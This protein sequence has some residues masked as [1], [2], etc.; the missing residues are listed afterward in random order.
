MNSNEIMY[1]S[2]FYKNFNE[3]TPSNFAC[4]IMNFLKDVEQPRILDVGCGNGRDSYY[5]SSKYN[6]TGIDI[7]IV[8]TNSHTN[9]H[10]IQG[11]MVNMDKTPFNV[12]YSRFTFHSITNEHQEELVKSIAPNTI[13]CIETRSS[14]DAYEYRVFGDNHYRNLTNK[15]YLI[16]LLQKYNFTILFSSESKDVA[17]YKEENPTCIRIICKN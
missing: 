12:I 5:L 3:T 16:N 7:S 1:W 8:P 17:I 6:T 4:F 11:D 9:L 14:K 2:N 15:D 13:L 10:F